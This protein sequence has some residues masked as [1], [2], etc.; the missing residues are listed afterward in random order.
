MVGCLPT[1][2]GPDTSWHFRLDAATSTMGTELG[3]QMWSRWD[4]HNTWRPI[5]T[6]VLMR[7]GADVDELREQM[8]AF[9]RQHLGDELA[10]TEAYRLQDFDDF[11][12]C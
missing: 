5:D 6:Y 2:P 7:P 9:L 3:R 1:T 8:P 10:K 4:P 11:Q 12:W